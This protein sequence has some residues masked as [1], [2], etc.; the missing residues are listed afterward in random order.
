MRDDP[1]VRRRYIELT[2]PVGL[3]ALIRGLST[4]KNA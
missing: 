2:T 4:V 1:S 3:A